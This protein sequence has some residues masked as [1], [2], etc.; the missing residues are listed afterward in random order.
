MNLIADPVCNTACFKVKIFELSELAV[1][2]ES[3]PLNPDEDDNG[4]DNEPPVS[5][6]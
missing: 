2:N 5:K 3:F 4:P 1:R 6:R